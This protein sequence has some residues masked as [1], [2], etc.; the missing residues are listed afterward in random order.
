MAYKAIIE[1]WIDWKEGARIK[2]RKP[3]RQEEV[4][5]HKQ[6]ERE[7]PSVDWSTIDRIVENGEERTPEE[8]RIRNAIWYARLYLMVREWDGI[9]DENEKAL[10]INEET[11]YP[12]FTE[13]ISDSVLMDRM[14]A[15]IRG[16][17]GNFQAGS[18]ASS[19][20]N[21]NQATAENASETKAE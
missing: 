15:F 13:M 7:H 3:S 16:P 1:K 19:N 9:V 12:I 18:T 20:T 8:K 6:I 5:L 14:I 17:L 10:P 4:D 2:V 21:G 11:K